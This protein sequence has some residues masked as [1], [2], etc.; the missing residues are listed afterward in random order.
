M[1]IKHPSTKARMQTLFIHAKSDQD[2]TLTS[3]A[4]K[5]LKGK[6]VGIV[7]SI[8]LLHAIKKVQAQLPK[9]IVAGQVLGCN[10]YNA[11]NIKSKVD[12]FLFVGSGEFHPIQVATRTGKPTYVFNPA[13]QEF[14]ELSQK[15]IDSYL[16]RKQGSI[17]KFLHAKNVGVIVSTKIGQ[18]N[19][20]RAMELEKRTDK[21]YYVFVSDTL[22]FGEMENFPFIDCWLNTACPRIADEKLGI[23]NINDLMEANVLSFPASGYEIPIWM[24][25]KGMKKVD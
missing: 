6:V 8:Q 24:S 1:F 25:K 13:T 11:E 16:K 5:G 15:T 3:A 12:C 2:V 17:L 23:V 22:N 4:V 7:T 19:F 21:K 18:K 9:S 20:L 14:G 10:S